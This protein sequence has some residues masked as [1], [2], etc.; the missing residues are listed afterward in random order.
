MPVGLASEPVEVRKRRLTYAVLGPLPQIGGYVAVPLLI[1]RHGRRHGWRRGRPGIINLAGLGPLIAGGA[2]LG[3][4]IASHYQ[5]APESAQL[6]L[7]PTYLARRGAYSV[8]RNP[9]YVGGTAMQIGWST[10]L[11]ST[12]LAG[13]TVGYLAGLHLLGVPFE[14]RLLERRFG[15]SYLAYK[16]QVPRWLPTRSLLPRWEKLR[17]PAS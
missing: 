9:M 10:L 15:D 8:T 17:Q 13:I 3:W 11:G 4:A 1:G 2:M 16:R 14:E 6:T 5:E 12:R 7:V